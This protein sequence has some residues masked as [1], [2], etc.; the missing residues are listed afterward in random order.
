MSAVAHWAE[1]IASPA[2]RDGRHLSLVTERALPAD[3]AGDAGLHLT[4]RGRRV[5]AALVLAL[6][7]AGGWGAAQAVAGGPAAIDSVTVQSGQTLSQI[8][9]EAYPSLP[10]AEAVVRVQLANNMNSLHVHP[11]QEL[12]IPR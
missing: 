3:I 5:L 6:V 10:V 12:S 1:P 9:H 7:C 11:G 8:A 4:V 2:R